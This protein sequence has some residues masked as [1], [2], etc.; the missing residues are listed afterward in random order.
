MRL[1]R[2]SVKQLLRYCSRTRARISVVTLLLPYIRLLSR[3]GRRLMSLVSH[4]C[5]LISILIPWR[6]VP[7]QCARHPRLYGSLLVRLCTRIRVCKQ[8]R[9]SATVFNEKTGFVR[10]RDTS[11]AVYVAA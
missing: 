4:P 10:T 6:R 5:V 11:K 1:R 9:M 2:N 8:Y 7:R 3:E